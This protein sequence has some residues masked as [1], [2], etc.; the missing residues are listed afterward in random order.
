MFN[1][2][3]AVI[4]A[5]AAVTAF[6][7]MSVTALASVSPQQ[8]IAKGI[9][10]SR[11]QGAINWPMVAASG[12]KFAFV[13]VGNSKTG[14][15]STYAVNMPGAAAAG[16]RVGCY[17]YSQAT[18]PES[19][20]VEANTL[21]NCIANMPVS[22]PVVFDME[23]DVQKPLSPVMMQQIVAAFCTT[24][25]N[26]GYYPMV[27]ASRNWFLERLGHTP[28]DQWV[29]QYA[30]VCDYPVPPAVWQASSTG[31][32]NGIAG[33]VDIDY[34]YKDYTP[35]IIQTGWTI[36]KGFNCFYENW[37]LKK[38]WIEYG[39]ETWYTD[40]LGH[41]VTGWQDIDGQRRYFLPNGPMARGLCQAPEGFF[42][43]GADG[44]VQKGWLDADGV[45]RHF[46]DAT[47]IMDV[48]KFLQRN[49]AFVYVGADGAA[50]TGWQQIGDS[51]YYFMPDGTM[52]ANQVKTIDGT[53]WQF[54]A[55]GVATPVP[56]AV[57]PAALM[58]VDSTA[59]I[60]PVGDSGATAAPTQEELLAAQQQALAAQQQALAAQQ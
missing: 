4:S 33:N 9:D 30:A 28:Y 11:Y 1:L 48:N 18:T 54:A 58:P 17:W 60:A 36:R 16:L 31:R 55:D 15:D 7:V 12:I 57:D 24:V 3:K 25:E 49:G 41:M 44:L 22:M 50:V 29:A 8:A 46:D 40:Q 2:K 21:I 53:A 59:P 34:L 56:V 13:R 14:V 39:G 37:H 20:V 35:L 5:L 27:Y 10:V 19:A 26:A 47:G 42:F 32:V 43:F 45:M 23:A 6:S 38:G 51:K 52:L